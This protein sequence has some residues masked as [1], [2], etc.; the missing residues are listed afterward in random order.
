MEL[1][2][3]GARL[4]RHLRADGAE[5][6]QCTLELPE[7]RPD[8]LQRLRHWA[9]IRPD[10]PL[11]SEAAA[12]GG[13]RVL[14][15]AQALDRARALNGLLAARGIVRGGRVAS[16][17]PAGIDALVLRLACL[18]GG[19]VHVALPP[20]AFNARDVSQEAL[21]LLA[22]ARPDLIALPPHPL[23]GRL[24]KAVP[25]ADLVADAVEATPVA[26]APATPDD[27]TAIFFTSGST[28][29]PKGVPITR[30]MISSNQSAIA[31]LWPF[32]AATPPVMVDWLPW[33]HVFGGLDNLFKVI[34]N[35]GTLHVD[36]AP[37][38]ST[39][40][41]TLQLMQQTA[42]TLHVA[43]PLGLRILLDGIEA[44]PETAVAALRRLRMIFFAGAGIEASLWTRL[45]ALQSG[46]V[47]GI[48]GFEI[49]T[50]YGATEAASTI[51]LSA[52]PLERPGELGVPLPGHS[53]ALVGADGRQE[54]RVRGPN[55]APCYLTA[56][57]ERA[58]PRDA[59]GF[60][61]SG[62]AAIAALRSDGTEALYFDGRLAEDFKLSS[63]VKVRTGPLRA[64]LLAA[65]ASLA[66]DIVVAGENRERLVVL[67][68]ATASASTQALAGRLADWNT[69]NPGASTRVARFAVAGFRPDRLKGEL[70]DK[71][72][73][74][75]SRFLR[76]HAALFEALQSG[77]TGFP[78]AGRD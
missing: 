46:S 68:F 45:R 38:L 13:R 16:L 54:L 42:P 6:F 18:V 67:V 64:G 61:C 69:A 47:P 5:L 27:W 43:V 66:D 32:L 23:A 20:F 10:Q 29:T 70:T 73:I 8:I 50:G 63:G 62:D 34:W 28:G 78:V 39:T 60:Y 74:V 57:G 37:S 9:G 25:L 24:P 49:L 44:D 21:D 36:A 72:Q 76:N 48:G 56:S 1:I 35:G 19:I 33:H 40:S 65:C 2:A 41:E 55:V 31:A 4:A 22:I 58:L 15:Y 51:C 53:V 75:Q 71:G 30:G 11:L 59:F 7:T 3:R 52:G 17:V 12:T 77:E 26:D 14:T